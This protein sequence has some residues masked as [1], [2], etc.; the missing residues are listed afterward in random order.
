MSLACAVAPSV[1]LLIGARV[2]QG[3]FG[4]LLVPSTLAIIIATFPES[5]RGAAIGSWTAWTGISTV[6]GPLAG[7]VL[8]DS[9]AWRWIFLLNVPLVIFVL[10]LTARAIPHTQSQQPHA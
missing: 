5:E 9:A 10:A 7:G 6:I 2:L 3:V 8:I 1:G 4:A